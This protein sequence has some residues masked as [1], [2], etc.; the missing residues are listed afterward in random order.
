[1][2]LLITLL[3]QAAVAQQPDLY[4]CI[5]QSTAEYEVSGERPE[6]IATAVIVDCDRQI[7]ELSGPNLPTGENP[8]HQSISRLVRE[9]V[10]ALV[11]RIRTERARAHKP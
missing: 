5:G 8:S 1:M 2:I 4:T 11:I 3:M 6:D 10:I 9:R 7:V